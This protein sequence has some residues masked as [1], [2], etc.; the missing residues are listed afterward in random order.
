MTLALLAF[1]DPARHPWEIFWLAAIIAFISALQDIAIDGYRVNILRAKERG[2]GASVTMVGG[3]LA[4]LVGGGLALIL[5]ENYG[6]RLTYIC[7]AFLM[8]AQIIPTLTASA[9]KK[10]APTAWTFQSI[11]IAPL[12]FLKNF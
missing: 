7:M 12:L 2:F 8:F 3:R 1:M 6:W 9:S 4:M 5:A 10:P 11:I